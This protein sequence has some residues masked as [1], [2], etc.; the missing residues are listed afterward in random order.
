MCYNSLELDPPN[1]MLACIGKIVEE[2]L[3]KSYCVKH[4]WPS[5]RRSFRVNKLKDLLVSRGC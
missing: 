1:L 3:E 5:W 2:V 4:Y